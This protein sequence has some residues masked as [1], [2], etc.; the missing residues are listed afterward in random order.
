MGV[1]RFELGTLDGPS[2]RFGALTA[3][4]GGSEPELGYPSLVPWWGL[5]R[6]LYLCWC[7]WIFIDFWCD[8][9]QNC[10]FLL[11]VTIVV[12]EMLLGA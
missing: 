4:R 2:G 1:R 5:I 8:L 12:Q 7:N 11:V 9:L 3:N 10:R 6:S